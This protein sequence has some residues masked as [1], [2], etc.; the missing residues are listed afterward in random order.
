M[1]NSEILS[2]YQD[3]VWETTTPKEGDNGGWWACSGMA[4]EAGESLAL[5]EKAYRKGVPV[6]RTVLMDELGDVLWFLTGVCNMMDIEL[7]DVMMH[8]V[9][10]INTRQAKDMVTSEG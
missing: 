7:C 2:N 5:F 4:A 6:D 3:W 1:L 9:H 10:K 8:N